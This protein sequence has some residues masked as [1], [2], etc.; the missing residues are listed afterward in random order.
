MLRIALKMLIGDRAKYL[1]LVLGV[2]FATLLMAQQSSIFV[3]L[4]LRTTSQIRDVH[5]AD[6]W[7]MDPRVQYVDETEPLQ[8][9][10][11]MRVRSIPGVQWAVGMYKGNAVARWRDGLLQQV[12]MLG[13]DDATLIGAPRKMI[14]GSI[15]DLKKPDAII[16]D[17]AGFEFNWPNE[18]LSTG[19]TIE[20]NDHR[21][22]IVGICEAS[23]PF[24]TFPI[25]Y[26]R[27]N[28]AVRFAPQQRKQLTFVLAKAAPGVDPKAL[29]ET[30]RAKSGLRAVTAQDFVTETID[31][32]LRRTGIPVNFGITVAL[33][34]LVG[35]A[36][37]G[38]TLYIF[39][40]ESL[41][42]FGALKAI[43]VSNPSIVGMVML[44]AAVVGVLGYA[45]GMGMA[46]AF[47]EIT[48]HITALRGMFIPWQVM[49]G[50]GVAVIVIVLVASLISVRRVLVL[51]PAVVFKG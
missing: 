27:Y 45:I 51:D 30:I 1:G 33:G 8:D 47:F 6:I 29:T 46:A 38:Q 39:I 17:R 11:V 15:E 7:V 18:P 19:K 22:V 31:Y 16:I 21:A 37:A 13:I 25:V 3:G 4:M 36:I 28:Q 42:Q 35:A 20:I 2:A 12:I 49:A 48:S 32:Y 14:I 23:P 5:E 34:F 26:T 50:T 9:T 41:K 44:Q 24:T 43:G 40:L 10:A